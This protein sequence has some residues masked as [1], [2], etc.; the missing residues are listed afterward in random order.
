MNVMKTDSLLELHRLEKDHWWYQGTRFIYYSLLRS[1]VPRPCGLVLDVGCGTGGN[2]KLLSQWG[3]V[4]GLEPSK[5]ILDSD[6]VEAAAL[7]QGKGES[8]PFRDATFALV[9]LLGVIEHVKDDRLLLREVRR[10][11]RQNGI[12]LLLTSAFG[13]LWSQHDEANQHVRRYRAFELRQKAEGEGFTVLFLTYLNAL[14]FPIAVP[15]RLF[16]RLKPKARDPHIDM[17]SMPEPFNTL[18][19][20]TLK[21]EG[22]LMPSMRFPVGVSLITVLKR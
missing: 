22:R 17:F 12:V 19:A 14:L 3:P 21:L 15:I 16:Q 7:V 18:L 5:I 6:T 10:V 13:F 20:N 4:I 2:L 11:C 9:T 8:L 1:Y